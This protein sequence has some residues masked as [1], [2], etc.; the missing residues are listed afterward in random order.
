ERLV[1]PAPKKKPPRHDRRREDMHVEQDR[2]PDLQSKDRSLN[3]KTIGGSLIERVLVRYAAKGGRIG[4]IPARSKETGK[5]VFI[6]E[7]SLRE[8]PD[9]Y[10]KYKPEKEAPSGAGV[11]APDGTPDK[12]KPP[13]PRPKPQPVAP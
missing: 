10:E 9:K 6:T 2:D 5:V 8:N 12:P 4:R 7:K 1:R 11:G 3:Y 13:R